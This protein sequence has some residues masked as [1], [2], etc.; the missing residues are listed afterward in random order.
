MACS[1]SFWLSKLAVSWSAD[2]PLLGLLATLGPS[3]ASTREP[4]RVRR[5]PGASAA[6]ISVPSSSPAPRRRAEGVPHRG[7]TA[8]VPPAPSR[9]LPYGWTPWKG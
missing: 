4:L 9:R 7:A 3:C 5:W 8:K 2:A 6:Q 1:C